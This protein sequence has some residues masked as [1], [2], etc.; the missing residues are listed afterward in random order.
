MTAPAS[1]IVIPTY[2]EADN[3]GDLVAQLLALPIPVAAI[4]IDDNSSDGTGQLADRLAAA[5]PGRVHVVHRPAKLGLGTA[6]IAGF[7]KAL[8]DLSADMVLTMDADFSHQPHYVP[9]LIAAGRKA[10]LVIGSRYAAGGGSQGCTWKRVLL[11][12]AANWSARALLGLRANDA[13]A[14]FRLY[15][16]AVLESIPWDDIRSSGYSFLI[17]M[18]FLC[19]RRGWSIA[20]VP[21]IFEDRRKGST[22]ISR[23]EIFKAQWTLARLCLRRLGGREPQ[24]PPIPVA[25]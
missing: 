16:R 22:K 19:Q 2:N 13:T 23:Q 18:L 11:S 1:A 6:Y 25:T 10:H 3:L 5:Y 20:E 9:Q 17:E 4:I 14:G 15:R 21:I 7:Q 12:R 8:D 24:S